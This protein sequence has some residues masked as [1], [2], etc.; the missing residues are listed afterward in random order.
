MPS[1]SS[2]PE[3]QARLLRLATWA[4]LATA[5]VLIAAKL[6][7]WWLTDS[8]SLLASLLDSSADLVASLLT[9]LA[10]RWSLVPPD[11]DHRFGH[12]KAEALAA[13]AQSMFILG[14]AVMLS[15]QGLDRLIHP[16]PLKQSEIGLVVMGFSI[17][18]TLALVTFQYSVA[19]RTGSTAIRADALHYVTDL[20]SG[21]AVIAALLLSQWG[22]P[23][24]DAIIGLLIAAYV[25]R[26]AIQI[27]RDALDQL[28][29]R[30][31]PAAIG[32]QVRALALGVPG[33]RG[34]ASLRTRQSGSIYFFEV[35]V[36]LDD[37]ITLRAAHDVGDEVRAAIQGAFPGADIV[38]HEEPASVLGPSASTA[39]Q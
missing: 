22:F 30:E 20:L 25:A 32:E 2:N 21:V 34:I 1:A 3:F 26:S 6:G 14:S 24:A 18:L 8:V 17:A 35:Y 31:L 39:A 29:D 11:H 33:V 4:S 36:V 38:I 19:R 28:M 27:A 12:G 15:L 5:L 7:G 9:F 13:L 23:R 37:A 10:V 16:Q